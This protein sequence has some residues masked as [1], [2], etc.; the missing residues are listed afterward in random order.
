MDVYTTSEF[1]KRV[2]VTVHTV[3]RWDREGRLVAKRTHTNRRYYTDEDVAQVLGF[4]IPKMTGR[5]I[6]YCRVSSQGQKA[7]LAN[8]H[9]QLRMYCESKGIKVDD[10]VEEIG[11]GLNFKRKKFL[12]LIESILEGETT[13]IVIAHKDRLARFGYDLIAYLCERSG[14]EMV[15]MNNPQLSPQEEMIQDLLSIVHTFSSRLYGL[16]NYKQAL[17]QALKDDTSAENPAEPAS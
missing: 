5:T 10:W 2:G 17:T 1:A 12:S 9:E 15:V 14:C 8:Q 16:R 13:Q 4:D 7:D 11:G 6:A 3:Q